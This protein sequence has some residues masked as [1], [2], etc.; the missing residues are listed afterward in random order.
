VTADLAAS[1]GP[2]RISAEGIGLL[3]ALS[4]PGTGGNLGG[5]D[6]AQSFERPDSVGVEIDAGPVSGGGEV[7]FAPADGRYS[8]G[9]EIQLLTVAVN[10]IAVIETSLPGGVAGY[11]FLVMLNATFA[12]GLPLGF[13]FALTGVGGL[14]GVN[15]SVNTDVLGPL[16]RQ[17]AIDHILFP[18]NPVTEAPA[19]LS[20]LE[21]VFPPVPGRYV[22]APVVQ[23]VWGQQKLSIIE[24]ELAL[25]LE[26][27]EPA[28]LTMLGKVSVSLPSQDDPLVLLNMDVAGALDFSKK[29]VAIDATLHDS[30]VGDFP[31]S[32]DMALRL[33]WGDQPNFALSVGGFHPHF[34]VPAGFPQLRRVTVD[35][36]VNG[37]PSLT[38]TGYFALTP[39]TA[40]VGAAIELRASAGPASV[41]G[42]LGFD[43]LFVFSPFS[44]T[45]NIDGGV[46]LRAF[47]KTF[48]GVHISATLSGPS[49]W[50]AI[51]KARVS[52][53][54]FHAGVSFDV[55]FGGG[56]AQELPP[57]DPWLRLKPA[58]QDPKNWQGVLPAG[59]ASVVSFL[60][61]GA[62]VSQHALVDPL[63][64]ITAKQSVVPLNRT[65]TQYGEVAPAGAGRY[66]LSAVHIVGVTDAV[67]NTPVQDFFAPG[68]FKKM[69]DAEKLSSPSFELMDAGVTVVPAGI[70]NFGG[71]AMTSA[72]PP[73]TKALSMMTTVI[74]KTEG[75]PFSFNV[76]PLHI[77]W[78]AQRSGSGLAGA[79]RVAGGKYSVLG[80]SPDLRVS[81]ERYMIVGT[82]DL[83][84]LTGVA[85][86]RTEAQLALESHFA[87]NPDD[88][89]RLQI[90]PTFEL[91][92]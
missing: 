90:V 36:G 38:L 47:G 51:G 67:A 85:L 91:A 17:G 52:V 86:S 18:A 61:G 8:G 73:I 49:P 55:T 31:V 50:H 82:R 78:M 92:A 13:G 23:I 68:Q 59:A 87:T 45:T 3:L 27:P 11:S 19:I 72:G 66:D 22:V 40:Q 42:N 77:E 41:H 56:Q 80:A 53:L 54:F 83:A 44:F 48:G 1:L 14:V 28:R 39:N 58:L 16:V 60:P 6:L 32:G 79:Q 29:S 7:T 46:E 26:V 69:P 57:L 64:A 5:L 10:G 63:G 84:P 76:P 35:L 20:D 70:G 74:D 21:S 37:N 30:Y 75:T 88:Q 4:F 24:A 65:I 33:N 43:A 81:D 34:P 89:G 25:I 9:L 2:V 12:P 62:D 15:R 71:P